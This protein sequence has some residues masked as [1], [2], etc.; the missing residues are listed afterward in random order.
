MKPG[1][2][3]RSAHGNAGQRLRRAKAPTPG[4][5]GAEANARSPHHQESLRGDPARRMKHDPRGRSSGCRCRWPRSRSRGRTLVCAAAAQ[6]QRLVAATLTSGLPARGGATAALHSP[7]STWARPSRTPS[8][9]AQRND[10]RSRRGM[11]RLSTVTA[12]VDHFRNQAEDCKPLAAR[13]LKPVDKAFLA[14]IGG[15]LAGT[16]RKGPPEG[17]GR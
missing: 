8:G 15:L 3:S 6:T 14:A 1:P 11:V 13:A 2:R 17:T 9:N 12:S 10:K 16:R 7:P 4:K 5:C